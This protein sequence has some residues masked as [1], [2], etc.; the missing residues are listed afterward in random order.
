MVPIPPRI[1]TNIGRME[2]DISKKFG[3]ALDEK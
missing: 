3:V 1:V 2:I